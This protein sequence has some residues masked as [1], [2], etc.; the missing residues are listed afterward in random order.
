MHCTAGRRHA[1]GPRVHDC[2]LRLNGHGTVDSVEPDAL[3]PE[4]GVIGL[5]IHGDGQALVR[6]ATSRSAN[7]RRRAS[8]GRDSATPRHGHRAGRVRAIAA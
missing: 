4:A 3:L 6:S 2:P 5:Q 7:C 1:S 8:D